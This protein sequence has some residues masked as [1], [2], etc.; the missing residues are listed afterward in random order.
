MVLL[1]L[2]TAGGTNEQFTYLT[3]VETVAGGVIGVA[4]NA[5]VLRAAAPDQAAPA[6][7]ALARQVR[8]LLDG[9]GRRA[10]R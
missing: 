6:V 4:T 1:S 2:I 3:I 5:I 8:E 9:D 7:S 10:A